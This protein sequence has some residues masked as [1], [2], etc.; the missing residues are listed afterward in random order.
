VIILNTDNSSPF[1]VLW[2]MYLLF[3]GA[4]VLVNIVAF[5][6]SKVL[7]WRTH[8]LQR[9]YSTPRSQA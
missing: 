2:Y 3:L 6:L 9:K 8:R 1:L 7:A 4:T 5:L